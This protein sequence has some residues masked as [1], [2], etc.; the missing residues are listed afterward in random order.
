M[1]VIAQGSHTRPA[2]GL[3]RSWLSALL[4]APQRYCGSSLRI[5]PQPEVEEEARAPVEEGPHA[6]AEC[7]IVVS[8]APRLG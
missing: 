5:A 2:T 7:R 6:L 8:P 3:A 1:I 4:A